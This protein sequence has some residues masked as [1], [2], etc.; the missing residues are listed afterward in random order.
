[1]DG[2]L[3]TVTLTLL[4]YTNLRLGVIGIR[5]FSEHATYSSGWTSGSLRPSSFWAKYVSQDQAS[6]V[7][8]SDWYN[9]SC[10]PTHDKSFCFWSSSS[11]Y[12]YRWC[13]NCTNGQP[14]SNADAT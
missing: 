12:G 4:H 9:A 10:Y 6:E 2:G 13:P 7:R 5:S 11:P 8:S 1:M 3:T 14:S